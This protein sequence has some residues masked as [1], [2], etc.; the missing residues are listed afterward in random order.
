MKLKKQPIEVKLNGTLVG[1]KFFRLI[2]PSYNWNNSDR[3]R[4]LSLRVPYRELL[5]ETVPRGKKGRG[6]SRKSMNT[7]SAIVVRRKFLFR[8]LKLQLDILS[9]RIAFPF[10]SGSI[11]CRIVN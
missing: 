3:A 7:I 5:A 4:L 1:I 2:A 6:K 8:R 9:K 10:F 11:K